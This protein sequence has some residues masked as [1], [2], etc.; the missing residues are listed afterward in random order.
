MNCQILF[1]TGK[2]TK[3]KKKK[4]KQEKINLFSAELA[5]ILLKVR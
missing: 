2:K 5:R 4:Q 3:N 1:S